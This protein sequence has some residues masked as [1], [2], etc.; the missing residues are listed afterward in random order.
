MA[1]KIFTLH[2]VVLWFRTS[3]YEI[4]FFFPV[5]LFIYH[6]KKNQ[7]ILTFWLVLFAV[8]CRKLGDGM[9]IPYLFLA[10]EYLDRV[11]ALSFCLVGV[12]LGS[13]IISFHITTYILNGYRYNFL[14][15]VPYPFIKFCINNSLWPLLFNMIYIWCF[16]HFQVEYEDANTPDI[17]LKILG[18]LA[19][20]IFV[21]LSSSAYFIQTN[22]AIFRS[23][24]EKLDRRIKKT[25][26]QRVNVMERLKAAKQQNVI[27]H[28]YIEP[29]L[30]IKLVSNKSPY[31]KDMIIKVF[32]QT[33]LNAFFIQIF[34]SRIYYSTWLIQACTR[35]AN[36]CC[37]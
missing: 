22:M 18:F 33:Q 36:T 5:H 4:I 28:S 25:N 6:I 12:S 34:C 1:K 30:R 29:P 35:C 19:G 24:S 2:R 3:F 16:V 10:P 37:C 9:G 14:I 8:V 32:D 20:E 23:L 15:N 13:F 21:F 31:H 26:L 11:N 17:I 27:I 7:I